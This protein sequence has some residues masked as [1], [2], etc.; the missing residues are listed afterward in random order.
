MDDS[1]IFDKKY[2]E[3][4]SYIK[5]FQF[6]KKAG[7]LGIQKR[8]QSF[9]FEFFNRRIAFDRNNFVD[10]AGDRI[11]FAVKV[12]LCKYLLMCPDE[13]RESSNRLVTFR[14]I[15][16]ADP[17]FSS[18]TSNTSKIIETSFSGRLEKLKTQCLKL[19]GMIMETKSY[20]L[21][22]RFRALPRIPVI[23]YFNDKEELMPAKAMFLYHDNARLYLDTEC[24][25]ITCTYLTGLLIQT[26]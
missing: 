22:V 9:I 13:I 20:D 8:D 5:D 19:G 16:N 7:I 21:G 12:V 24:L 11:S 17:L 14:E 2:T 10:I 18:F 4:L 15:A 6:S 26:G 3:Y 1:K 25:A 23:L